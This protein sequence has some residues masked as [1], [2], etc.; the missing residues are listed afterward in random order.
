MD[1]FEGS[2]PKVVYHGWC[3]ANQN[4]TK[5]LRTRLD[6]LIQGLSTLLSSYIK[7]HNGVAVTHI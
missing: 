4:P 5:A 1:L 2:C 7:T 3:A 6:K